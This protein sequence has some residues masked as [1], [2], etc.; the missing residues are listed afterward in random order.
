MLGR[1]PR[2][3]LPPR[4]LRFGPEQR[5]QVGLCA[6]AALGAGCEPTEPLSVHTQA[7]LFA[8]RPAAW[9]PFKAETGFPGA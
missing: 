3:C 1:A 2:C 8:A 5:K 9:L 6:G 7:A 4:R